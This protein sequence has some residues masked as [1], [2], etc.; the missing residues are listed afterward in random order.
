MWYKNV[1]RRH[2]CDM[3]IDDWD[4]EFLSRFSPEGYVENL[5]AAKIENAMIYFQSH[6]GLCYY[7]TKIGHIHKAFKSKPD[8]MRRLTE[9]CHENNIKVTG[10]YSLIYNT[11]EHDEHPEWRMVHPDMQSDRSMGNRA[12]HTHKF[13]SPKAA[14]YGICCPNNPEYTKF[15]LAQIDEILEYFDCDALFFDMPFWPHTCFCE[16]CQSRWEKEIGR[17]F[18]EDPVVGTEEYMLISKKKYEW[19]GM[20]VHFIKNY[21]KDKRPDIPI[22]YNCA[23]AIAGSMEMCLTENVV[24]ASDYAGG[25]LYGGIINQSITCKFYKNITQN[26][27]F[28]YMLSRCKPTLGSHTLSRTFDELKSSVMLT[29]AHHGAT[30]VIDAIDPV[31]TLDSRVYKRIGDVFD[32]ERKYEPY[33]KGK[34]KEDIGIYYGLKSSFNAYAEEYTSISCVE[35][36][37]KGFIQNN[38][39]FGITGS[40]HELSGYKAIVAPLLSSLE[41]DDNARLIKYVSDGGTLYLSGA[42]NRDLITK[43]LD[44]KICGRTNANMIYVS[45]RTEYEEVFLEFN[46]GYPLPFSGNVPIVEPNDRES[47][48]AFIKLPYTNSDD[49]KFAAIHSDPPGIKTDIPAVIIKSYGKGTVIWS[50]ASIEGISMEEYQCILQNL[51]F[52]QIDKGEL[53]FTSDAPKSV[54][55]TEFIDGD[56]ILINT[57]LLNEN[58]KA[59]KVYPFNINVKTDIPPK[60]VV[61]VPDNKSVNFEYKED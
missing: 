38:I 44:C 50:A 10:Y 58:T 26:T 42:E 17:T 56:S 36:V 31:G 49:M 15:V 29:A 34:M 24:S 37:S 35:A 43:L 23:Y 59:E 57:V 9:L 48:A 20:W 11:K 8:T 3:H 46:S 27:P 61:I 32:Y 47:V 6:T 1:Y 16:H 25:D 53:S 54:E 14:R 13:A 45:P 4:D 18:T 30:L 55:I 28:E 19:M 41:A 33:F 22:E 60:S 52:S 51:I 7:P 39:C 2:L 40:F 21:I 5:K 12:C